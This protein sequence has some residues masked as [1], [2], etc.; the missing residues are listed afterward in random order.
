LN[1]RCGSG[2]CGWGW[3]FWRLA[4]AVSD[5]GPRYPV[6][7]G[8]RIPHLFETD[9]DKGP[10]HEQKPVNNAAPG[11][12]AESGRECAGFRGMAD[13]NAVMESPPDQDWGECR[14]SQRAGVSLRGIFAS[15]EVRGTGRPILQCRDEKRATTW[16]GK[17]FGQHP[18]VG[19][20]SNENRNR[21]HPPCP[22][23]VSVGGRSLRRRLMV[24]GRLFGTGGIPA[25]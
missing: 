13:D 10:L 8:L 6:G 3:S 11:V 12:R 5:A 1:V 15:R 22:W 23:K 17:R 20:K 18:P 24:A 7:S 14:V 21:Y 19:C 2:R 16:G 25:D 9:K 4:H